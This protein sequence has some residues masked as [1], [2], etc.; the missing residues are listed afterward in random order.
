MARVLIATDGGEAAL[1]ASVYAG[2]LLGV[3][4]E[5]KVIAVAPDAMTPF[6]DRDTVTGLNQT[7]EDDLEP[8]LENTVAA[9]GES[10]TCEIVHGNPASRIVELAERERADLIVLGVR[11]RRRL[12][13]LVGWSVTSHVIDH[14]PCLVLVAPVRTGRIIEPVWPWP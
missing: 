4:H 3:D 2:A 6:L 8:V 10:A 7:Y 13:D 5:F 14:A 11:P 9:L 12:R 1:R